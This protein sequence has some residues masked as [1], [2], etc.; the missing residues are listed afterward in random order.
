MRDDLTKEVLI[1]DHKYRI[2]K[3]NPLIAVRVHGWLMAAAI[4]QMRGQLSTAVPQS[5]TLSEPEVDTTLDP[6]KSAEDTVGMIWVESATHLS[7]EVVTKI[8]GYC[9]QVCNY[10]QDG[11]TSPIPVSMKDGR[12]AAPG[13]EGDPVAVGYLITK[14]LQFSISPFFFVPSLKVQTWAQIP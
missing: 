10:F 4:A 3:M 7:E 14:S 8:Q 5:E 11:S 9:L 12:L 6:Q 2:G 13:L 1:A